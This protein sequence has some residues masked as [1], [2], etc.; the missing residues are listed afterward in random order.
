MNNRWT[1]LYKP[2]R[3]L[4]CLPAWFILVTYSLDVTDCN[5][6]VIVVI[7]RSASMIF[8]SYDPYVLLFV[9]YIVHYLL[10]SSTQTRVG[11]VVFDNRAS[12]QVGGIVFDW[13][14]ISYLVCKHH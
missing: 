1:Q 2:S 10:L 4:H 14:I 9:K 5:A 8:Y 7:D 6:D 11:V 3:F 12:V 13:H